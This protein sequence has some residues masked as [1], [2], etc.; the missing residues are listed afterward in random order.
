MFVVPQNE[1]SPEQI[2]GF[3]KKLFIFMALGSFT[4]LAI[5]R[6]INRRA[7]KQPKAVPALPTDVVMST[8]E[9]TT[10]KP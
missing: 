4:L 9:T 5:L 1:L 3:V 2:L 6:L 7:E 8:G 10:P